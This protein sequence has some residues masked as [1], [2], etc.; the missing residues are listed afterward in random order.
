MYK[1]G[2]EAMNNG[3][4]LI[5]VDYYNNTRFSIDVYGDPLKKIFERAN[6]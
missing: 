5:G 1:W 6:L 2:A 4:I 3:K